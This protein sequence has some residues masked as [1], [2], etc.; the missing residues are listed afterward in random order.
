[1]WRQCSLH[2]LR[3]RSASRMLDQILVRS[4]LILTDSGGIQEEAPSLRVPVLVM[5]RS[6][7][8][9]EGVAAGVVRL[10][11]TDRA[12]IVAAASYLLENPQARAEM[13][14][15]VNPYGDGK[16]ASRIVAALL[17]HASRKQANTTSSMAL[18]TSL[19]V[20]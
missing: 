20:S 11:G 2:S 6:T 4:I 7:E 15:G 14:S 8:R 19:T 12:A 1:V 5:R 18:E 9:P 13:A 17:D 3:D 16:A 10:V